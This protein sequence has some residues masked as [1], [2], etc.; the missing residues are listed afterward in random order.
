M[1]P[2]RFQHYTLIFSAAYLFYDFFVC[3]YLM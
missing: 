2:Y 3:L 1:T